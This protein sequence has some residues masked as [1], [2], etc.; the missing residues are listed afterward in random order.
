V[1]GDGLAVSEERRPDS[2]DRAALARTRLS[3][4]FLLV[5]D[6]ERARRFY[7]DDLGLDVLMEAGG[8]LRVGDRDGFFLG[9]EE[10]SP[11]GPDD[12]IELVIEV[13]DVDRRYAEL[14]GRGVDF[15]G[16]PEEQEWGAR[17]AWL[18]D[19]DGRRLSIYSP[20]GRADSTGDG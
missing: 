12:G 14:S 3:H 5:S 10:G 16:P 13:D 6:L 18:R 11:A 1:A 20:S 8:Y 15:E 17:H 2:N 9:I 7:V 4:L 19:P